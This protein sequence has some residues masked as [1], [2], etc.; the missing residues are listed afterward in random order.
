MFRAVR[1]CALASV[2]LAVLATVP[3][4]AQTEGSPANLTASP[5]LPTLPTNSEV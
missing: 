4:T 1:L 5:Y 2:A 3:V